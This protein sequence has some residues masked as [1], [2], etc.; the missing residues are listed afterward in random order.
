MAQPIALV[1]PGQGSQSV[2][3]LASLAHDHPLILQTFNEASRTLGYDVWAL[4]QEGPAEKLNQ[5]EFTQP[6]LLTASIALWR[7]W[8]ANQKPYP[9]VFAGHSLGEY[10]ALV[11]AEAL[12]FSDALRLVT[13]R[14][15]YMQ[16]AVP[17]GEGAMAAILG[18][19]DAL[20][21]EI[22]QEVQGNEVVSP[23]NYNAPG[24]IVISGH[25]RAVARAMEAA[26][27]RGAKRAILLPVSVP[28]HCRL[29]QS[30]AVL[31]GEAMG[32]IPFK[33]PNIPVIHNVDTLERATTEG[34]RQALVDQLYQPVRWVDSIRVIVAKG[35]ATIWECGPGAVLSGLN[36][37]IVTTLECHSLSTG[38]ALCP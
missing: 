8:L 37:R 14:G 1:F 26:K 15:R 20:V 25:A 27:Q 23:A 2:G 21:E 7:L 11:A 3:M 5:T 6:A 18:L 17:V 28:S 9:S 29:M 19:A 38:E 33:L 31:L 24:Q 35:I 12:S 16:S 4:I 34:I 32:E 10:S 13:L 36:K 30:A 22:C